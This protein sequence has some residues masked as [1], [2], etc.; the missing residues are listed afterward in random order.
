MQ[1]EVLERSSNARNLLPDNPPAR[2]RRRAAYRQREQAIWH[3]GT[4]SLE[5]G[6]MRGTEVPAP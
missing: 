4:K 3:N 1:V 2:R 5:N 6:V